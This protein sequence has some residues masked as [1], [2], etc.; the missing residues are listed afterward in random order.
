MTGAGVPPLQAFAPGLISQ[1]Y[2]K[3]KSTVLESAVRSN[4]GKGNVKTPDIEL[5]TAGIMT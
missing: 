3:E 1:S 2:R 4:W 5:R